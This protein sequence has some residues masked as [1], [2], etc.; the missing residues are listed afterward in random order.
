MFIEYLTKRTLCNDKLSVQ[1]QHSNL[2]VAV[3]YLFISLE[4]N[5]INIVLFSLRMVLYVHRWRHSELKSHIVSFGWQWHD[6]WSFFCLYR[7]CLAFQRRV[8]ILKWPHSTLDLLFFPVASLVSRSQQAMPPITW[9]VGVKVTRT[10]RLSTLCI[11]I[12]TEITRYYLDTMTYVS[13]CSLTGTPTTKLT[14]NCA[15]NELPIL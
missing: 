3:I 4:G 1:F 12:S 15:S 9:S 5:I 14:I 13:R 8:F 10:S 2:M 11:Y 7:R 6:S